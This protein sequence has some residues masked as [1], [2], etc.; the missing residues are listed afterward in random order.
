MPNFDFPAWRG[1]SGTG[2]SETVNPSCAAMTIMY[3]CQSGRIGSA[4]MISR[5]YAF[6]E[7]KSRTGTSNNARLS[8]L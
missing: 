4:S 1:Y 2:I 5:R 6:T 7:F 3:R 8:A